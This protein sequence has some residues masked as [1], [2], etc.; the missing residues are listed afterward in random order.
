MRKRTIFAYRNAVK[1]EGGERHNGDAFKAA[2]ALKRRGRVCIRVQ[3]CSMLPWVRPGDIAVFRK[4]SAEEIRC[5]DIL[6]FRREN[7][8]FVHRKVERFTWGGR[9]F[10]VTK[11]DANPHADGVI[12]IPEILGRVERIYRAGRRIEFHSRER[13]TLNVLIAR[14][15]SRTRFW[16]ALVDAHRIAIHPARRLLRTFRFSHAIER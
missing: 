10:I 13:R 4:V 7:R 6:L 11:G 8:I 12:A 15:S 1:P 2:A 5:G 16:A 9:N 3:G 14:I